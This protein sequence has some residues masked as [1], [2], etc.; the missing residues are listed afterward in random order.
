MFAVFIPT[1]LTFPSEIKVFIN[2]HRN[3]WYSTSS[4]YIS[5][6]LVEIPCQLLFTFCYVYFL[7]WYSQ[8]GDPDTH[9]WYSGFFGFMSWRYAYFLGVNILCCFIAQGLG[10]LIGGLCVNS[11]SMRIT[12]SSIVLL[13]SLLFSGFF[14]KL[15][16]MN[17]FTKLITY[18]S[19]IRFSFESLLIIIYGKNRCG[20]SGSIVELAYNL[21]DEDLA[22]NFYWLLGHL[23][24]I[25]IL[26]YLMLRN[27][28]DRKFFKLPR[29]FPFLF[30]KFLPWYRKVQMKIGTMTFV[31]VKL[32]LVLFAI[33]VIVGIIIFI[34]LKV[35]NK[36]DA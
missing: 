14:V 32:G 27:L 6:T 2:E 36:H 29:S 28:G 20:S 31:L 4:Y 11:F 25:R 10:F 22:S 33:H 21:K 24:V 35:R 19:F 16:V 15:S 3:R 30:D 9:F 34:H 5:K 1:A 17:T 7:Y 26:A 13:F 12:L 18:L 23:I 8:Q